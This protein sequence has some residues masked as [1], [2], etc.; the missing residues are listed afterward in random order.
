MICQTLYSKNACPFQL[1]ILKLAW[2]LEFCYKKSYWL[3]FKLLKFLPFWIF[4]H[5]ILIKLWKKYKNMHNRLTW[6]YTIFKKIIWK[7]V[8]KVKFT[9]NINYVCISSTR[10]YKYTYLYL[11]IH[12]YLYKYLY[13]CMYGRTIFYMFFNQEDSMNKNLEFKHLK[14]AIYLF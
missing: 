14:S 3:K 9:S 13:S 2:I 12:I 7:N 8:Q 6:I 10:Y 4:S 11:H 5:R 1:H